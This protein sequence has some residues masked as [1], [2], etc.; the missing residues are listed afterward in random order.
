M[1]SLKIYKALFIAITLGAWMPAS[2]LATSAVRY[3]G[4]TMGGCNC[5]DFNCSS[6]TVN[7]NIRVTLADGFDP[8]SSSQNFKFIVK[9][10]KATGSG[11]DSFTEIQA[12]FTVHHGM[13]VQ[14]GD[15]SIN[16]STIHLD[17]LY[18]PAPG[19]EDTFVYSILP[20]LTSGG[21]VVGTISGGQSQVQFTGV[22]A[23]VGGTQYND[24][25]ICPDPVKRTLSLLMEATAHYAPKP[26]DCEKCE[27]G[28]CSSPGSGANSLSSVGLRIGLGK[29][30]QGR[31][32]GS[33]ELK[34]ELPS[35]SLCK[36]GGLTAFLNA[37]FPQFRNDAH[38]QILSSQCL[39][40]IV[41][42]APYPNHKYQVKF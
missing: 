33:L 42:D 3:K 14:D 31:W 6:D 36:T 13:M 21:V 24:K 35:T 5:A 37:D 26:P 28:G 40:D 19:P 22:D 1:N 20:E 27:V 10:V 9:R 4:H 18:S 34:S 2:S 7:V 41:P 17:S 39:A 12:S 29:A 8:S 25:C 11:P 16:I 15:A 30:T 23:C 38:W 32:V